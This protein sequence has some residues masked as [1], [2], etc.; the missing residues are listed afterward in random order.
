MK[1]EGVEHI[2]IAVQDLDE[3]IEKFENLLGLKCSQR[4]HVESNKVD[5]AV[6]DCGSTRIELV[7][8]SGEGSPI[9]KFVA[10]G[11]NSLHHLCFRV[12]DIESWL[13]FLDGRGVRLIDRK[14][15]EGAFGDRIAFVSP[16]SV[17]NVLIEFV[18][19]K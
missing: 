14:P 11:G 12:D 3:C 17:C 5:V 4:R 13:S 15:R 10:E 18:E 19:E 16:K 1:I 9:E 6:F 2:G 8:P 7:A